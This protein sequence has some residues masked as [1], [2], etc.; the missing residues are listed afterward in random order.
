MSAAEAGRWM[1]MARQLA[2]TLVTLL[3]T[4]VGLLAVTFVISRVVP[5]DPV[6]TL[7][8]ERAS[9]AQI[10]ETRTRLGLDEPMY[11]QFGIYVVQALQGDLGKSVRT[12]EPVADEIARYFPATLELSTLA[13]ILGVLVGV[14]AGVLAAT[15]PGSW[16]DQLVRLVGLMGY[17]MPVFWL[18]LVGLLVFY[19]Q[20]GWVSGPGRLDASFQMM[21]E[22]EVTP[23]TG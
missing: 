7:L 3:I 4:F 22:F 14:P 17:S 11:K 9:E 19:G 10:A 20:L 23:V 5:I 12:R 15:R 6:T 2:G 1:G 13:T 16:A 21:F 8:G 18:G